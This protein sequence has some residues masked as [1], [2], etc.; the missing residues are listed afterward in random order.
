VNPDVLGRFRVLLVDAAGPRWGRPIT[1][2]SA[3]AGLPE[4]AEIRDEQGSVVEYVVVYRTEV[5]HIDAASIMVPEPEPGW[6]SVQVSG[7]TAQRF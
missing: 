4:V 3:P 5:S 1:E 6:Y 7:T 2:L